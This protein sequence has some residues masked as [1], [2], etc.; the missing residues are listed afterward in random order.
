MQGFDIELAKLIGK[1]IDKEVIIQDMPFSA[2]MASVQVGNVDAA[3]ST[4]T[5]TPERERNF[6]FSEPYYYENLAIIFKKGHGIPDVQQLL[7]KNVVCQLGTTMEIWLKAHFPQI[8]LK[9]VDNNNQA[10]EL[11]KSGY[12]DI[13]VVDEVQAISFIQNNDILAYEH[14]AH[15]GMGYSIAFA[16]SSPFYEQV[17]QVLI[18]LKNSGELEA[19]EKKMD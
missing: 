5:S 10:V 15:T 9:L 19:L 13:M 4:I 14:M 18:D 1:K 6:M 17:N 7:G 2:V 3:I 16:Q 11:L 8:S 12:A